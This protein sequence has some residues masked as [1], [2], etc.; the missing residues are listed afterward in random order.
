MK[1]ELK[2][3]TVAKLVDG[4]K[5]SG[6][7]GVVGYGGKLNI[8]PAF[9]R[10]FVYDDKKRDAVIDTLTKDFPL[11]TMYW[12]VSEDGFEL[13]DGQQR[14]ISICRFVAGE[15]STAVAG[16]T[17]YFDGLLPDR[18]Q[19]ILDYELSIYVCEGTPS[20]K[21]DWFKVINIAG[22]KLTEQELRNAIYTG[23]WLTD[24]KAWF[25]RNNC[26]AAQVGDG[27]V[28]GSPIRQELLQTT[29]E[30]ITGGKAKEIEE[31]MAA[32]QSDTD[33]QELWQYYQ[34]V[35][36]WVNRI[37][38]KKRKE[39]KGLPWGKF[40]NEYK[41]HPLNAKTLE[42][43]IVELYM[44]DEVDYKKGIYEYLLT[45]NE[46]T[47][48]LRGFDNKTKAKV[49]EKQKGVCPICKKTYTIDQMEADH[50]I[51]WSK[52]GKTTEENCQMLCMQ[53]NRRK[54]GS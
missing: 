25:S 18:K 34:A 50:V 30:W 15:F 40:Y 54:S 17:M 27:L 53:D 35:I 42:E 20:E 37:F 51:P 41:N 29:L 46:K 11:N 31:Y 9:Q 52:G 12:S 10:E 14:T 21:L 39:M 22:E 38:P 43:R 5:D 8:R 26:P 47:L 32:H 1:I 23:P 4:Y 3:I 2:N 19:Q 24:A 44:D 28:T 45:G 33:A 49:F 36:A 13:L 48:N 7:N 6:D 16:R